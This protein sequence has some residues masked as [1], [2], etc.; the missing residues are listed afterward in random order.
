EVGALELRGAEMERQRR[1]ASGDL[2]T[3]RHQ[4]ETRNTELARRQEAWQRQ[5][6]RLRASG[7]RFAGVRKAMARHQARWQ[8]ERRQAD[9]VAAQARSQLEILR[10]ETS[11][12]QK[13]LPDL[14]QRA[15]VA[16]AGLAQVREQLRQHL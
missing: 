7:R 6:E 8:T 16:A 3:L 9:T 14:E 10:Q 5:V 11:Q 4:L 15:Q 13:D 1:Q 12:L 2:V